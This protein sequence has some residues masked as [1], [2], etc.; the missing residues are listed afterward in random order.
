M[1][2]RVETP[3][4]PERS[5]ALRQLKRLLSAD[6]LAACIP[7][8]ARSVPAARTPYPATPITSG[9][10]SSVAISQ[11]GFSG[12][13]SGNWRARLHHATLKPKAFAA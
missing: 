10:C 6:L 9:S 2:R 12:R 1:C 11:S 7:S 8:G 13:R 3:L 5:R 4:N